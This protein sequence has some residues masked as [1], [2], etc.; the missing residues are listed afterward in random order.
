MNWEAYTVEE[1]RRFV[2]AL[3][4]KGHITNGLKA[5]ET[6]YMTREQCLTVLRPFN[7]LPIGEL[8]NPALDKILEDDAPV[9]AAPVKAAPV[10]SAQ[11]DGAFLAEVIADSIKAY[12]KPSLDVDKVNDLIKAAIDNLDIT[13]K[14]DSVIDAKVAKIAPLRI[15]TVKGELKELGIQHAKFQDVLKL[16]SLRQN[17]WLTGPAGSGKTTMVESIAKALDLKFE[18]ISVGLQTSKSDLFGFV[19]AQG[20]FCET[21]FFRTYK[22]GGVFLLDEVDNGNANVLAMINAATSN[23]QCGFPC[24]MIKKHSDFVMVAAANTYGLGAGAVYVG[25][26]QI[27]GATRDRFVFIEVDYD[28]RLEDSLVSN[29]Q[30]LSKVRAIRRAVNDLKEKVI[31]SPRASILGAQALANGFTQEQCLDMY[32]FKGVASDIKSRILA[33]S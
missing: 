6:R 33:R 25:R 27:D 8:D 15:E 7:D 22:N 24:G 3:I 13:K 11:E 31:V 5:V 2:R 23:G 19:N 9:K 14:L 30:W 10:K 1:M 32:I 4:R 18:A 21:G 28:Q 17:V 26:N 20:A 29:K 16:V 12:I